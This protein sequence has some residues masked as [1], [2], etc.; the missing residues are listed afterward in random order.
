M[1]TT[2][3]SSTEAK[4]PQLQDNSGTSSDTGDK[5]AS[6]ELVGGPSGG[7]VHI[8][9]RID[10]ADVVGGGFGHLKGADLLKAAQEKAP[11]LTKE[12]GLTDEELRG[13]AAGEIPPPPANGPLHTTDLYL[14]PGGWQ[15]VPPGVKP[16]DAGKNAIS[17]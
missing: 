17:R 9:G 10:V 12:H 13:V 11:S 8:A 3:K 1:A 4:G 14:T 2:D 7:P 6:N 16:E 5:L 15:Q